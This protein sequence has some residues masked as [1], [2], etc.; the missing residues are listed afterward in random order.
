MPCSTDCSGATV[1]EG[2]FVKKGCCKTNY[3][4]SLYVPVYD[5][6]CCPDPVN[7]DPKHN[8]FYQPKTLCRS[9]PLSHAEY[10]RKLKAN[11]GAKLSIAASKAVTVGHEVYKRTIWTTAGDACSLDSDLVLPAVPAVLGHGKARDA[12]QYTEMKGAYAG[13]GTV[14]K[15]DSVNRTEDITR[16]RRQGLAI[17]A[18]DSFMAP[19]NMKRQLCEVCTLMGTTDVDPGSCGLCGPTSVIVSPV[20]AGS[21][22]FDGNGWLQDPN[23]TVRTSLAQG[24][25]AFTTEFFVKSP[26]SPNG[27]Y[28]SWGTLGTRLY[29]GIKQDG[30]T[31]ILQYFFGTQTSANY[32]SLDDGNW[33][34]VAVQWDT[35]TVLIYVDG[36]LKQTGSPL[37]PPNVTGYDLHIGRNRTATGSDTAAFVGYLSNV[38]VTNRA[39][40]SGTDTQFP[41][42]DVTSV[43]FSATQTATNNVNALTGVQT[44][45]LLNMNYHYPTVDSSTYGIDMDISGSGLRSSR[46]NPFSGPGS[47]YFNGT[48]S[49]HL[50]V[51][52]DVDL[53]L[54]TGDFTIEWFQRMPVANTGLTPRIFSIGSYPNAS[55]GVSIEDTVHV[56]IYWYNGV[57]HVVGNCNST[58]IADGWTHYAVTRSD[59]ITRFFENGA[60]LGSTFFDSTDY[61]DRGNSLFI[62]NEN[63][64][65]AV[66]PF[67]GYI[68]NFR[69]TKGTALYTSGG[70]TVPSVPLAVLPNTKLLLLAQTNDTAVVDSSGL[71][72]VVL[73]NGVTW[74]ISSAATK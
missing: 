17:A 58:L 66:T 44:A 11:G 5:P 64:N 62:G 68:S 49:S 33:H 72:K 45:A 57:Q 51:D 31:V 19:A 47:L 59:N 25:S 42:F 21:I 71:D 32:P 36:I 4:D 16:L 61:N 24:S 60:Q 27:G 14:S 65:A 55:I 30:T 28:V 18:D 2:T 40:Y 35:A 39:L 63:S 29:N 9:E 54:R 41:N 34:H 70:F 46:E 69:W 48:A 1:Y 26:Y 37:S 6:K 12:W 43:P 56:F 22:Y 23:P 74:S 67:N 73:Q 13:R 15:F 52:N 8:E 53:R 7:M 3:I 20:R 10:I 50:I 38:R